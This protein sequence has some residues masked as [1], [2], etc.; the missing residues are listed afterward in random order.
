VTSEAVTS[1]T[2]EAVTGLTVMGTETMKR[3]L[4]VTL[5][6]FLTVVLLPNESAYAG[7]QVKKV[8]VKTKEQQV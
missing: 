6:I 1:L 2:S 3:V 4:I 5:I 8:S 7:S